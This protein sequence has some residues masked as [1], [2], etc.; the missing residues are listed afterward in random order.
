MLYFDETGWLKSLNEKPGQPEKQEEPK[1]PGSKD[2][3]EG[4]S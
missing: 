3:F 1:K 2:Y 4:L